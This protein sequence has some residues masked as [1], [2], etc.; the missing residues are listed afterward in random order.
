MPTSLDRLI[1]ALKQALADDEQQPLYRGAKRPGLFAARSG[2][3][4]EAAQ[5]ALR[6]GLLEVVRREAR[7]KTEV[8]WVR[9]TPLGVQFV[10]QHES[11]RAVL[12]ELIQTLRSGP[13]GLPRW[14]EEMQ[15]QLFALS[16]R[17]KESFEKHERQ[18][19]Q[20]LRR[21]EAALG[22]LDAAAREPLD[23]WQL[24]SVEYLRQRQ[25]AKEGPCPL[26]ELFNALRDKHGEL[27]LGVFHDGLAQM[28]DRRAIDLVP[29]AGHLSDLAEPEHALL[30]G[31]AVYSAARLP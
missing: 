29:F 3:T 11:P 28:R 26:A 30:E 2:A 19:E 5:Q 8:E 7:G 25:S 20:L 24:A 27:S 31:A 15:A 22:R 12:A 18:R 6:D 10:H 9:I 13:A 4:G 1:D 16:R 14:A 23:G 17:F 21:A